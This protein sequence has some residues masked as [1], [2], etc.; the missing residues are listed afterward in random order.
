MYLNIEEPTERIS[1]D[2]VKVWR[3]SNSLGHL[4]ALIIIAILGFFSNM[5]GWFD[6]INIVLYIIGGLAI[7]SAVFSIVIEPIYLQRTWRY[8]IDQQFVQLKHGKWQVKHTLIPMEK[9][10][11]VRSEQG[12]L[13]RMFNL[14][15]IEI[16]TTTSN[17]VIPGIPSEEAK[18]LKAQIATYAKIQDSDLVEGETGA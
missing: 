2:A 14:Y 4:L 11:Y 16:G 8:Q 9:V 10:E 6:W 15:K 12:P 7:L 13:M 1:T 5:F 3:I 18:L 17:H